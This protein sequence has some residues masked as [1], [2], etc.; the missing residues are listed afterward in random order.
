[1]RHVK[2]RRANNIYF[3]YSSWNIYFFIVLK[4]GVIMKDWSLWFL[5][6]REL[7]ISWYVLPPR[8]YNSILFQFIT[9]PIGGRIWGA[10]AGQPIFVMNVT[11]LLLYD[12]ISLMK[13]ILSGINVSKQMK[14]D[15]R[16]GICSARESLVHMKTPAVMTLVWL[17]PMLR[18]LYRHHLHH[19]TP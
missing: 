13:L 8:L 11:V 19:Q 12:R 9:R 4:H 3:Y 10:D 17:V 15:A 16:D 7:M 6:L 2:Q 14:S 1:M 18:M 5:Y